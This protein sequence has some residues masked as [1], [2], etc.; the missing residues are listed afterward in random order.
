MVHYVEK[1]MNTMCMYDINKYYYDL[2]YKSFFLR[3]D[4]FKI[5]SRN[6]VYY[7]ILHIYL[8]F[9]SKNLKF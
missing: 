2:A 3:Y 7:D 1:I 9:Y 4:L 5:F 8:I 6:N